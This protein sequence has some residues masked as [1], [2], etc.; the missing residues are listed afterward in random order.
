MDSAFIRSRLFKPFDSTKG[1]DGM[2]IG[3]YQ[4]REAMRASGGD[5]RVTSQPGQGTQVSLLLPLLQQ[6]ES[7]AGD[8]V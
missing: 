3:A 2:G 5:L 6:S 1:A 8:I 7:K 4:I